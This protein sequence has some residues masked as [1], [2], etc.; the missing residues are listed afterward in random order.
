MKRLLGLVFGIVIGLAQSVSAQ[1]VLVITSHPVPL[2]RPFPPPTVRPVPPPASY[3]IRE[4]AIQARIVDQVARVQ[5]SQSFVNTGSVQ[6]EVQFLFPLPHDGAIDKL[7]L[8]VDG[9]EFPGKLMPAKEARS[10]YEAIVRSNKDPALLEWLGSGLFQTS[11]F[12]VPP[13]AE[14]KVTL[15]YNQLLKKERGLTDFLFP[16]ST[17]RYTSH[18]VEK[19]EFQVAIESAIDIKNVYSPTHSIDVKRSDARHALITYSRTNEIPT[20]DF[21]LLFDVDKGQ[22][23]AR[24]ISYRPKADDDG[25]YLLLASPQVKPVDAERPKKTVILVLDRSGSMSGKKIEQAKAAV[26][27]V[28]NNLREG[29]LF[30]IVTYDGTVESFR[31]ELERYNDETRKAALGHVEG[32]Y[33]GGGTNIHGALTSALAQLKDNSRPNYVLFLTDGLP[34]IGE[35][36]EAK[37]CAAAREANSVR[38]RVLSFGVGYD[39]NSRLLDRLSRDG[40]GLSEYVRPDEDIEAHVSTVYNN[41]SSPVLT[42]ATVDVQ[43]DG[44]RPE[45]GKAVN[46]VYPKGNFDLFEGQQL[47][48]VGRYRKSGAAKIVVS[49]SVSGQT[50]TFDFPAELVEKS[51]DESFAFVE[52]LW[53]MRR[54]GEIIDQLDLAGRNEE[55]VK[56]LV[57][58]STRHGILTPYTSFLADENVRPL[59]DAGAVR[60]ARESLG[61]LENVDGLRGL[62]Q[63]AEKARFQNAQTA[64]P[65]TS[66]PTPAS[67]PGAAGGTAAGLAANSFR[68]LKTDRAVPADSVRQYGNQTVYARRGSSDP[69]ARGAE[70]RLTVTPETAMLDLEKDKDQIE[71]VERFSEPY[72]ALI[73]ENTAAENQILS[74]QRTDEQLLIRLRGK[75]FLVK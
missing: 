64:A 50:Q 60:R 51:S 53:A 38:A 33:P 43:L 71:V 17:A 9:K 52:K 3:K 22:V 59:A 40:F 20:T 55:L 41:I 36:N 15:N 6:M 25:Y 5:V 31:P 16:L 75:N 12:P 7:T 58:L 37:I 65:A 73:R 14:R 21:R 10:V 39:V 11:V 34:T 4:L 26:K 8:L 28:L 70:S 27:F 44:I 66:A 48:V 49:G 18:A 23:G 46:R 19:V 62:A 54:I 68:D 69:A 13:G 45:D 24:V 35:T 72:F 67:G 29:D 63:R 42:N 32:I 61:E 47:V 57:D 1:G 30:N 2:P 74:Q 56:E